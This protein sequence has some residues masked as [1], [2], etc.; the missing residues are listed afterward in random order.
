MILCKTTAYFVHSPLQISC[1]L[2]STNYNL[3]DNLSLFNS[4]AVS[5]VLLLALALICVICYYQI[6][7]V[8]LWILRLNDC[9]ISERIKIYS[10]LFTL[11][12]IIIIY[13]SYSQSNLSRYI[14]LYRGKINIIFQ[15]I[16]VIM[17]HI[18]I[19]RNILRYIGVILAKN[20]SKDL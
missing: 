18:A 1:P 2:N 9:F 19:Y 4:K 15:K 13:N 20:I 11:L 12:P 5:V 8:V 10:D 6:K 3:V 14:A 7:S 16:S 17:L